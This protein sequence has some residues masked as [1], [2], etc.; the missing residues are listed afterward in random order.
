M[1]IAAEGTGKTWDQ[2][3]QLGAQSEGGGGPVAT[4]VSLP[5]RALPCQGA[6]QWGTTVRAGKV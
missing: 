2:K 4:A 5:W 6:G 1:F 3:Q